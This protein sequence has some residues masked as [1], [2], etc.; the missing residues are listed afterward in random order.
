MDRRVRPSHR[1]GRRRHRADTSGLSRSGGRHA[2]CGQRRVAPRDGDSINGGLG[3]CGV[4]SG[5]ERGRRERSDA[6]ERGIHG[7]GSGSFYSEISR[8][9]GCRSGAVDRQSGEKLDGW[10]D[11]CVLRMAQGRYLQ[12][13][14]SGEN[15]AGLGTGQLDRYAKRSTG[16]ADQ[17]RGMDQDHLRI[18]GEYPRLVPDPGVYVAVYRRGFL[19]GQCIRTCQGRRRRNQCADQRR[20]LRRRSPGRRP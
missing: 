17:Q 2:V 15:R 18:P 4:L 14:R 8:K 12:R 3:L 20:L 5:S 13:G 9:R 1:P 10:T 6:G 7:C 16:A 19:S 11:L